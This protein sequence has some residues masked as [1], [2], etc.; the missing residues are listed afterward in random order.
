ML[1]GD[2]AGWNDPI[3]GQG[4]SIALRDAR[5]IAEILRAA[6]DWSLDAFAPYAETFEQATLDRIR[7]LA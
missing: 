5:I 7:A 2:A 3:I 4:L 1:I 6:A